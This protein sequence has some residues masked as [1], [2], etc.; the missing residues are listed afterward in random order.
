MTTKTASELTLSDAMDPARATALSVTLG[1]GKAYQADDHLPP[2]FHQIYFWEAY[3]ADL[4]GHDGH[5]KVGVAGI[6]PDLGLPNRMWAGGR[7]QFKHPMR[8]GV[9][10]QKQSVVENAETK[11]GRRGQLGFVTLRHDI[12]QDEVLCVR[13][14]QDLVYLNA[15]DPSAPKPA[16][17]LAPE[18]EDTCCE[19]IFTSTDLFRYSALTFNGHKIHYDLEHT[20]NVEGHDHL[21]VHGPLL[22]QRLMLIATA[23]LGSLKEFQFRAKSPVLCGEKIGFCRKGSQ[24]WVRGADGRLCMEATA[25]P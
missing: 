10:A 4:L 25:T 2:F 24:L 11:Q 21:V 1:L 15:P 19:A 14:F 16:P 9:P 7:L 5:P 3:S 6:I 12:M 22:A 20:R 13:E 18:D 8:A 23:E 17:A